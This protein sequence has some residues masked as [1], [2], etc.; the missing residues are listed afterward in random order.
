[1]EIPFFLGATAKLVLLC[2]RCATA[3][4]GGDVGIAKN[5]RSAAR[6]ALLL[7]TILDHQVAGFCMQLWLI[8]WIFKGKS[9]LGRRHHC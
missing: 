8:I 4:I 2:S 9:R 3:E 6:K 1:M 5:P 7:A